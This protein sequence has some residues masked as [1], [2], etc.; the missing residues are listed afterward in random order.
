MLHS[1]IRKVRCHQPKPNEPCEACKAS[2]VKCHF[3]DRDRY[4][5]ERGLAANNAGNGAKGISRRG[6]LADGRPQSPRVV[7][8]RSGSNGTGSNNSSPLSATTS[9]TSVPVN[10]GTSWPSRSRSQS[11]SECS[12]IPSPRLTYSVSNG[13]TASSSPRPS[14]IPIPKPSVDPS[15]FIQPA[16]F[17]NASNTFFEPTRPDF[18]RADLLEHLV[19]IF[20]DRLGCQLPFLKKEVVLARIRSF[21]LP[22]HIA[23]AIAALAARYDLISLLLLI[24]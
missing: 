9:L 3:G 18:P 23:N 2:Q 6:S 11:T 22:D 16:S 15:L 1:R 5:A 19:E 8:S 20:F 12:S 21:S 14:P 24:A 17:D 4:H 13:S 10:N 7:T